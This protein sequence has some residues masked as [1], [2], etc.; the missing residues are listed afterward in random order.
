MR[1]MVHVVASSSSSSHPAGRSFRD[2]PIIHRGGSHAQ[3]LAI[4]ALI[5]SPYH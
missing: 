5:I 3:P 2:R 4:G 1:A